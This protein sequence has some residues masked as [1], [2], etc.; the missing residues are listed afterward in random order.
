MCGYP[1]RAKSNFQD[2]P[3]LDNWQPGVAFLIINYARLS[4]REITVRPEN[5]GF[6]N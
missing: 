6:D 4:S 3:P 1:G 2:I 5:F